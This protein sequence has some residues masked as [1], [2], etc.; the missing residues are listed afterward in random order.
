VV[1]IHYDTNHD[2]RVTALIS[3][4]LGYIY[5]HAD[6]S[7]PTGTGQL[8]LDCTGHRKGQ[9]IIYINVDSNQFAEKVNVK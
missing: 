3:N 9:Y 5:R 4:G 1:T 8:S 2:D 7:Y 6:Q